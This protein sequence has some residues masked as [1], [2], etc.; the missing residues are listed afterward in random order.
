MVVKENLYI[1][2]DLLHI[3][4]AEYCHTLKKRFVIITDNIVQDIIA[5]NIQENLEKAGISVALFSFPAGEI[6]KTR[7]T[8]QSLEDQLLNKHYG[9]DTCLIAVGGG[10]VTDLAGFLAATYCRG[11]PCIYV[12]TTLLAMVDASIG[13]K[14]GVNTPHGK[15]LIG[16]FH[17]PQA[18]FVDTQTLKTLPEKEWRNGMAEIIKH[19]L[20]ADATLFD[21]LIKNASW[22]SSYPR[23]FNP[24]TLALIINIIYQSCSIKKNIVDQDEKEKS[25]R[26]LLNYGHTIGHAI[27]KVE[28][29]EISHGEA[30]AIGLLVEAYLS[31]QCGFL[32][33][34]ALIAIE[35]L[36]Q[37]YHLPLQTK[38]F[39]NKTLFLSALKMDKK[40]KAKKTH[41]VLLD[42]I[43]KAH[44]ADNIYSFPVESRIVEQIL[45]WAK[46]RFSA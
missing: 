25:I 28:N 31:I 44:V 12:P 39:F 24:E 18:I 9:R 38:A 42:N 4:L 27:E 29:Y 20:I 33:Q 13:G 1:G 3:Q 22:L 30:V 11:I 15:N 35:H 46:K 5:R 34:D 2:N 7:E 17:Q 21:L 32:A 37:T 8:K 23:S 10:V 19:A 40:S 41:F 45:E 16:S 6:H 43:G 36:L 26:E 14:T